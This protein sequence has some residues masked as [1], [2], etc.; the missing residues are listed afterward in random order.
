[1]LPAYYKRYCR[2]SFFALLLFPFLSYAYPKSWI[3]N[4]GSLYSVLTSYTPD[5]LIVITDK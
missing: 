2:T 1:M 5:F 3:E 4:T